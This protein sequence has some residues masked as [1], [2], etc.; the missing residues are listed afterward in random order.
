MGASGDGG[1]L[2]LLPLAAA[3]AEE[4]HELPVCLWW[5]GME[6]AC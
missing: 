6:G 3:V 5:V 1:A 2:L 4:E